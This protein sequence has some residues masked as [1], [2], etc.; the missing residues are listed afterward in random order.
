MVSFLRTPYTLIRLPADQ[1]HLLL[2]QLTPW[3]FSKQES[4]GA[5]I[6]EPFQPG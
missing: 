5:Y 6:L 1:P 2:R 4:Q 3:R